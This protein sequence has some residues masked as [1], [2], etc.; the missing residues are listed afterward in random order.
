[1]RK[2]KH[3]CIFETNSGRFICK[4]PKFEG[5]RYPSNTFD[6]YTQAV[7]YYDDLKRRVQEGSYVK[8]DECW[9]FDQLV[10]ECCK[11]RLIL[12]GVRMFGL[13]TRGT[14]ISRLCGRGGGA[15]P[16]ALD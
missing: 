6:K 8:P 3:K 7:A 10:D 11:V 14:R 5:K 13:T 2:T 16:Q 4:Q 1:M 15:P 9:P 12:V